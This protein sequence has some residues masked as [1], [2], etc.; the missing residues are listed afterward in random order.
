[1]N[2]FTMIETKQDLADFLGIQYRTLTYVLY[3]MRVESFYV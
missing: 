2:A 1:M 3:G